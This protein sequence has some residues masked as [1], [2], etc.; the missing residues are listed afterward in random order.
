[1][2]RHEPMKEK[3][4]EEQLANFGL[5]LSFLP[6]TTFPACENYRSSDLFDQNLSLWRQNPAWQDVARAT[7][8][9]HGGNEVLEPMFSKIICRHGDKCPAWQEKAV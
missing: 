7:K 2:T 3:Q 9:H 6:G 1:V 4:K 5:Q 8:C